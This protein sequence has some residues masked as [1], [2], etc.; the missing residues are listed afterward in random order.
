MYLHIYCTKRRKRFRE[1][2]HTT[3]ENTARQRLAEAERLVTLGA[4][5][6]PVER[7][8]NQIQL[9]LS[10]HTA[11]A[12]FVARMVTNKKSKNYIDTSSYLLFN[13]LEFFEQVDLR[14][15]RHLAPEML[16]KCRLR[17]AKYKKTPR[18]EVPRLLEPQATDGPAR[19]LTEPI[20]EAYKAHRLDVADADETTVNNELK[21]L[22]VFGKWLTRRAMLNV[23]PLAGVEN[24]VD[25]GPPRGRSLELAEFSGVVR[26]SLLDLQRWFLVAGLHGL[27][28]GEANHL[29][30]EDINIEDGYLDIRIH[31][32]ADD[33]VLW[34]PKSG[35]ERKVPIV[36]AAT[37]F[38]K[39]IRDL[40]TDKH[41]H[42][43]GVH[44]RRK[45]V[46]RAVTEAGVEGGVRIHDFRHTAYTHLKQALK[47]L[48]DPKVVLGNVKLIFGH[49]DRSMD[50]TYDHRTVE[51]LRKVMAIMPL[52]KG[53]EDLLAA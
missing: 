6:P 8:R 37:P 16:P 46:G 30:P 22:R 47:A 3:D 7:R 2:A 28:K 10:M 15:G 23:N 49:S 36:E 9:N 39:S 43:L 34:R 51:R 44:D 53:V 5:E 41:G 48:H 17:V 35:K 25:D 26:A 24:V 50:A 20:I 4:Y 1:S 31:R 52:V 38:M 29:R 12:D 14:D 19:L 42:V 27:R 18:H 11:V 45:A 21:V 32:K 40:S 33:T 13:F